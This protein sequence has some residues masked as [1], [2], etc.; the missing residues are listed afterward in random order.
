M[1]EKQNSDLMM[2]ALT[3]FRGF[4]PYSMKDS[5]KPDCFPTVLATKINNGR[6]GQFRESPVKRTG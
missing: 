4:G 1:L 5:I 3:H 6:H 2:I